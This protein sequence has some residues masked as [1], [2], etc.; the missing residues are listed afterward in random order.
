MLML[1]AGCVPRQL[2]ANMLAIT[3]SYG[4]KIPML[5]LQLVL[6]PTGN[7]LMQLHTLKMTVDEL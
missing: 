2:C 3:T 5:S 6:Q 7:S 4:D 1:F